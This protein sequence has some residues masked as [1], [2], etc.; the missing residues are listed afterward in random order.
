MT[1]DKSTTN[2]KF[3]FNRTKRN[4]RKMAVVYVKWLIDSPFFDIYVAKWNGGP[5]YFSLPGT[6]RDV[7]DNTL[8]R[9][10]AANSVPLLCRH[11]APIR[12]AKTNRGASEVL[13]RKAVYKRGMQ[14]RMIDSA[15]NPKVSTADIVPP[16]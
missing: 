15:S 7:K 1:D 13:M 10:K 4:G 14:S 16:Q 9:I 11:C 5:R 3:I 8:N 12:R 2:Y 6:H